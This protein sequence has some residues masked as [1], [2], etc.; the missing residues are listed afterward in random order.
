MSE[1]DDTKPGAVPVTEGATTGPNA[2]QNAEPDP[3]GT[4]N[5][6]NVSEGTVNKGATKKSDEPTAKGV[7]GPQAVE[8]GKTDGADRADEGGDKAATP[9]GSRRIA[10]TFLLVIVVV[11][12]AAG[13]LSAVSLAPR[14]VGLLPWAASADVAAGPAPS[15]TIVA[16]ETRIAAVEKRNA[17]LGAQISQISQIAEQADRPQPADPSGDIAGLR[18]SDARFG[19]RLGAVETALQSTSDGIGKRVVALEQSLA[20]TAAAV[21]RMTAIERRLETLAEAGNT[22]ALAADLLARLESLETQFRDRDL[23][24]APAAAPAAGAG[25]LDGRL[26]DLEQRLAALSSARPIDDGSND[27]I[28]RLETILAGVAG[29]I[30]ALNVG[31]RSQLGRGVALLL[32]A[33]ALR[34][35][36]RRYT[37]YAGELAVLRELATDMA[38]LSQPPVV[39]ALA[40]LDNHAAA[41]AATVAVLAAQFGAHASA[42]VLAARRDDDAGWIKQTINRVSSVVTVRRVGDIGGASVEARVARAE[43]RMAAGDLVAAVAELVGLDGR[44]AAAAAPWLAKAQTRLA[45][46]AAGQRVYETAARALLAGVPSE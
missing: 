15:E 25:D 46:D 30:D 4:V 5:K 28:D 41:G 12:F 26:G 19:D 40:N 11:V 14:L 34:D 37:G 33:G 8:V 1:S 39:E 23:S 36:T 32:A 2:Q 27:R 17:E 35:A 18:A 43:L 3:K 22:D 20:S 29:R 31:Q 44:A 6:G 21:A 7:G 24:A 16:L 13:F 10:W 9:G 42:I 38:A 45:V